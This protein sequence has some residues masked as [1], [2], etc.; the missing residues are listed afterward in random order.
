[1]IAM[2]FDEIVASL[3]HGVI[4]IAP[5]RDVAVR[6]AESAAGPGACRHPARRRL[7][8]DRRGTRYS[9]SFQ[10][11]VIFITAYPERLLIGRRPEP[12]FLITKPFGPER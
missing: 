1:M 11:P 10:V 12:T 6:G 8:R 3:G 9:D 4:A 5:T 2:D 7:V